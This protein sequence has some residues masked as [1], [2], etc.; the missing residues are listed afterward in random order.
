MAISDR[1]WGAADTGTTAADAAWLGSGATTDVLIAV[2]GCKPYSST[3]TDPDST[4]TQA[5]TGTS[6][7]VANGPNTG[8]V[9]STA[10]YKTAPGTGTGTATFSVTSG[11]PTMARCSRLGFDTGS[12]SIFAVTLEDQDES[13]TTVSTSTGSVAS[14]DIASGDEL[15]LMFSAKDD[16]L[17]HSVQVLTIAGCTL[18][19]IAWEAKNTTTSGNDGMMQV[20]RCAV[21]AGTSTGVINY[22]ATSD[23]S[24]A[25]ATAL[26]VVRAREMSSDVTVN[27]SQAAETD[28]ANAGALAVR[29]TGAQA[30]ETDTANAGTVIALVQGSQATETDAAN[31]GAA[32]VVV[33]GSQ[34][35][36]TDTA[37]AGTYVLGVVVAG[38]QAAETDIA[39]SGTAVVLVAGSQAVETDTA[40][41][42]AL[43]V[44][45]PGA[46]AAETDTANAG[47]V[48]LG[49]SVAGSQAAET[50]TA[51]AGT[52]IVVVAGTA[53]AESDVANAGAAL[54]RVAGAQ[55]TETDTAS[56]GTLSVV[57]TGSQSTETD[58]ANAGALAVLWA[59]VQAVE[60]WTAYAGSAVAAQPLV[61]GT[62]VTTLRLQAG[63]S[64]TVG[65]G[66]GL[67][68]DVFPAY[69]P[70]TFGV[71]VDGPVTTV[72]VGGSASTT[73]MVG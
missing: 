70:V 47:A 51:N 13:L 30:A 39:N 32:L 68:L 69:F 3:P 64:A 18:S 46:Q 37:N 15:V 35:A 14:G 36:E 66:M 49:V 53:G 44:V 24:G 4:W 54:V 7:S 23:M 34:A 41:V 25:S 11:S 65:D 40:N 33:P 26:V 59:G 55:A 21:T 19:T 27:G 2:V 12:Y 67:V 9:R 38:S 31:A 60:T 8:S 63:T 61:K 5:T 52:A 10:F 6:G 71:E 17:D 1:G 58:I 45:V 42:G 72:M 16:I 62:A 48:V 43:A 28:T 73:A 29:L 56:S 50:D 20:G 57:L 22:T